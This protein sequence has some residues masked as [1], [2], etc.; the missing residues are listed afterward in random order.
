MAWLALAVLVLGAALYFGRAAGTGP[1]SRLGDSLRGVTAAIFVAL[2]VLFALRHALLPSILAASLAYLLV[3]PMI[4]AR[5]AGGTARGEGA[6]EARRT[7]QSM[8]REEALAVL[9]LAPGATSEDI[10]QAHRR[11]MMKLHPDQGGTDYLAAKINRAKE[12]LL[13]E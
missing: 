2:A 6:Q 13:G 4:G 3:R 8:T 10:K 9:G 5:R 1:R 11:L 12:I 7:V